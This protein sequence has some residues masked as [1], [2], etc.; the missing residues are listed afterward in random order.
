MFTSP[1]LVSPTE[2][3]H[4]NGQQ[5]SAEELDALLR[6]VE[7]KKL[8]VNS[9]LFAAYTAAALLWFEQLGLR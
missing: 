1:H 2:R 6:E 4:A 7:R 5:I 9:S 3:F 8:A